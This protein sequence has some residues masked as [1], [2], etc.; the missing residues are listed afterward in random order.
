MDDKWTKA[1]SFS[2]LAFCFIQEAPSSD[3]YVSVTT[4]LSVDL[5]SNLTPNGAIH[6]KKWLATSSVK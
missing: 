5:Q 6:S 4:S 1:S 2:N 3:N